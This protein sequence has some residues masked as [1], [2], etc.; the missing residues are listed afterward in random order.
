MN[1][2][3][4]SRSHDSE[5]TKEEMEAMHEEFVDQK[6]R[7]ATELQRSVA[8]K[9][10][11]MLELMLYALMQRTNDNPQLVNNFRDVLRELDVVVAYGSS[12]KQLSEARQQELVEFLEEVKKAI[13]WKIGKKV[14]PKDMKIDFSRWNTK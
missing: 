3:T 10:A 12:E 4:G 8:Q 9:Q 1:S 6:R 7:G 14:P 13:E 5:P 2:E 11:E